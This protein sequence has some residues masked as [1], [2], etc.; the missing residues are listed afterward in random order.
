MLQ[1]HQKKDIFLWLLSSCILLILLIWV[2][3]LTRLTG[4]GLSI[5]EWELFSGIL[6]PLNQNKWNEYFDLY[7]QI[8]EYKKINYGMSLS[9]FKFIFWWEYIHRVLARF[10][11]LFYIIPFVYFFLK[12]KIK[13][14]EIYFFLLIFIFFLLQGFMGWYMVK[15]GLVSDTDVSHYRLAAHLSLAIIIYC[16]IFW[17][18]LNYK[19][20]I[21]LNYKIATFLILFLIIL[22]LIQII[23]GAFTSGLNAGLLYQT[24]PLMNEQFIAND[25]NIKNIISIESISNPSYVQFLHRLLAYFIILYSFSIYFFYFRRINVTKPFKLIFFAICI[26]VVLGIFTLISNLNIYLASLHQIGSILLISCT[27]YTLFYVNKQQNLI[28]S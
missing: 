15:S 3:G 5:T 9:E 27:I 28:D 6:P 20:K 22:I 10:L 1:I 16:M 12:N 11:V 21:F 26:Q 2:G 7:K 8:P 24:W 13:K 14:N 17:S 18:L 4:S 25:V 19:K 23:W